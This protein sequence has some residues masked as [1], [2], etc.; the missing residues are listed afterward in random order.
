MPNK[1]AVV[2]YCDHLLP[3]SQTFVLAQSEGLQQFIPYYVGSRLLK[4]LAL[5]TERT[6]VVN[7]GGTLG[8]TQEVIYK[9]WGAAPILYRQVQQLNPILIHAH[10]GVGGALVLPLKRLLKIPMLVTFHG[11]DATVK[12]EYARRSFYGHR[13]YIDR[14]E[15]LK[16]EGSLFIAVSEFIKTK[17]L[18]QGFP[19][20]KI[21]V[22]YIGVDLD[23]F[24][25]EPSL[26]REPVVLFV[27]R[28]VEKKGCEYLIQAMTKVQAAMPGVELVVIGDGPL[29]S[30][31]ESMA[32][33][34][35]GHYRFLGPQP[36]E[37]VRTWMNRARV[38]SVPSITAASND[39]EGFGIV[40]AEAQAMGLPVVSFAS[41][42][43]PEAVAH[44]KTGFLANEQDSESLAAYILRL[45]EDEALWHRFS[46][47][48]Q[49][50]VLAMF[51]LHNQTR[52]L[53]DIYEAVL[54]GKP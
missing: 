34:L 7:R 48:G 23:K 3:F 45:L 26:P 35:L 2:V 27:G 52:K 32:T 21:V 42:G 50:R 53:E 25:P 49:E 54:Q 51:N 16:R 11:F 4:N 20:E 38:F 8:W 28:L 9:I 40:F 12:D 18:E 19:P 6:L 5:P 30:A 22:H 41:G 36:P 37:V 47:E 14:R 39:A 17:L 29:R 44:G 1:P 13:V 43:I 46:Q 31:L 15:L 24:R 10:F 33:G